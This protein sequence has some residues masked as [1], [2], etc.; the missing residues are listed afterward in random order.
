MNDHIVR[1]VSESG[2]IRAIGALTT[3]TASTICKRH[4]TTAQ[5][6]DSLARTVTVSLL[7]SALL[8]DNQKLAVKF[9]GNGPV[10]KL[11]AESDATGRVRAYAGVS[12]ATVEAGNILGNAGLLTVVKDIGMRHPYSGTVHL[13]SGNIADDIA[14]YL[15]E[16]E[17]TPSAVGIGTFVDNAGNLQAAGGFLIQSLP[18]DDKNNNGGNI[19]SMISVINSLPPMSELLL[20]GNTPEQIIGKVFSEIPYKVLYNNPASFY[21]D[22]SRDKF[23]KGLLSL[24]RKE[25]LE[26]SNEHK[27]IETV[28]EF[29]KESYSFTETDINTLI[30]EL[31]QR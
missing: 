29:C 15:T 9:E 5:V 2:N 11:V 12:D 20:T 14:F 7:M 3:A 17:Q 30:N 10:K 31:G 26:I 4:A 22:C 23:E 28:C 6:T 1:I 19:E 13:Q 8:K 25:L 24:G 27:D 18:T 16:S 21:C